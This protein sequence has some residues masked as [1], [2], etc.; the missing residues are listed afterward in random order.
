MHSRYKGYIS[1][2]HGNFNLYWKFSYR[3]GYSSS[4]LSLVNNFNHCSLVSPFL[5]FFKKIQSELVNT[6]HRA[7][8]EKKPKQI[9]KNPKQLPLPPHRKKPERLI[10][11]RK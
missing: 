1:W 5:L 11:G 10:E 7:S 6:Y 3:Y 9:N 8:P 4:A 2:I